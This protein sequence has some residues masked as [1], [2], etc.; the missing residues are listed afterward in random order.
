M[1]R[2]VSYVKSGHPSPS[3]VELGIAARFMVAEKPSPRPADA[4]I[5]DPP[6]TTPLP[7]KWSFLRRRGR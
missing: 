6:T 2:Y 7:R 3:A 5:S 4:R 1:P